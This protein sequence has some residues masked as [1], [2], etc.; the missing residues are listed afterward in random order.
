LPNGWNGGNRANVAA[1][2]Y[3]VPNFDMNKFEYSTASSPNNTYLN[4][5]LF[6]A[7]AALA[8]GS[9]AVRYGQIRAFGTVNED[10]SLYKNFSIVEKFKVQLRA[11]FL[12]VFNR[13]Q[14]G[15]PNT[16]ITNPLFGQITSVY[17]NRTMQ[18]GARVDF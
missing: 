4:K 10:V 7:P 13:H 12:D 14:L 11:D 5:S 8:L 16:D 9:S 18:L 3:I 17:G 2:S 6:S 1:G 15:G